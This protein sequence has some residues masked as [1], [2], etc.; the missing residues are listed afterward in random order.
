MKA[1]WGRVL[2]MAAMSTGCLNSEM[3]SK[4]STNSDETRRQCVSGATKELH[5]LPERKSLFETSGSKTILQ[6]FV[7]IQPNQFQA[8]LFSLLPQ[9]SDRQ[10]AQLVVLEKNFPLVLLVDRYCALTDQRS[11]VINAVRSQLLPVQSGEHSSHVQSVSYRLPQKTTLADFNSKLQSEECVLGASPDRPL[12]ALS[13]VNDSR[14]SEQNALTSIRHSQAWQKIS[15][16]NQEVVIA[17]VDSGTDLTH[18]DLSPTT[19]VNTD[20]IAGNRI[21]DD[22]NGFVDDVNGWNGCNNN[23][24]VMGEWEVHHGEHIHGIIGAQANNNEGIVGIASPNVKVMHFKIFVQAYPLGHCT[25]TS[26]ETTLLEQGI[27]YAADNGAQVINL[28]W[29]ARGY[30]STT[31]ATIEYAISK[32]AVV[33]AAAAN[34]AEILSDTN[35][36]YPAVYAKDLPGLISVA[37][38]DANPSSGYGKCNFS[39]V[40][41]IF[42]EAA[43]PGCDTTVQNS[44]FGLNGMLS[45]LRMASQF[46]GYGYMA[47]TS[48]ATPA[49]AAAAGL[50]FAERKSKGQKPTPAEVEELLA[51]GSRTQSNLSE[52]VVGGKH[53]DLATLMTTLSPGNPN[54][55]DGPPPNCP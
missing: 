54:P 1:V 23:A 10:T 24:N 15:S 44:S 26:G 11:L 30:S 53:L 38:T 31:L 45:T 47:G 51:R 22:R 33:V 19:W 43:A 17:V 55:G 20:E 16:L 27:R 5:P 4:L 25:N 32:G 12:Q 34:S 6:D 41:N 46:N 8:G 50:I 36:W 3:R 21:D 29:G 49:I 35:P 28:S 2:L 39:N 52:Y 40:S 13:A 14:Y 37:A 42:V 48:M 7:T 18:P 9:T